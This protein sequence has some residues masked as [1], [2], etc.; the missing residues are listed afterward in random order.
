MKGKKAYNPE[1]KMCL[2]L[3]ISMCLLEKYLA[4]IMIVANLA[5]SEG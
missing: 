4:K 3:A 1:T 5:K 2:K